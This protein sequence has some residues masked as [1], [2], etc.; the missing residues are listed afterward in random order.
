VNLGLDYWEGDQMP[1]AITLRRL[2]RNYLSLIGGGVAGMSFV[3]NV[4]LLFLDF[5]SPTQ[6]PY[7]GIITYMILPGVTLSG[8]GLVFGGAALRFF[9]LRRGAQVVELPRLD[10]NN[11]RHRL[12]LAGTF[13]AVILFLG[14]SGIG[15][16]ESYH[17]TD[18]VAF[19]G[20][21][22]HSVSAE[23]FAKSPHQ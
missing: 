11:T 2:F 9:R 6:N 14:L 22:C 4:V 1:M 18:S 16:Y 8:L 3:V 21:T 23:F 10:L 12:V 17:Y 20:K 7:V 5:L 15:G 13:L 19:C